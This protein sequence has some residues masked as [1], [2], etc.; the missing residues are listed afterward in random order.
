MNN[1]SNDLFFNDW[2]QG[3]GVDFRT[4]VQQLII[5]YGLNE[6]EA[7]VMMHESYARQHALR[8]AQIFKFLR[9]ERDVCFLLL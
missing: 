1:Y 2:A 3:D 6:I 7:N 4:I 5:Q 8:D 9:E